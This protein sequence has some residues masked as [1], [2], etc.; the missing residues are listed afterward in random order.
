MPDFTTIFRSCPN[1]GKHFEIRITGK[2]L[3]DE[4]VVS[5]PFNP[6]MVKGSFD[7]GP[8]LRTPMMLT[9]GVNTVDTKEFQYSYECKHCGH[10]WVEMVEKRDETTSYNK[11]SI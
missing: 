6:V 9:S 4:Q 2:K 3:V 10:K 11:P 8:V 5:T 7:Q 1:C